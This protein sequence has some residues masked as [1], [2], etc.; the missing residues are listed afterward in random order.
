M[1]NNESTTKFKADISELKA[2][3]QEASRQIR[4]ANAEFKAASSSMED[5]GSTSEGLSAKIKQLNSVLDAEKSKLANLEKQ[6]ALT[7]AEFGENSAAADEMRIKIANQQ[8]VVNK[9]EKSLKGYVDKLDDLEKG[10]DEAADGTDELEKGLKDVKDAA[11]KAEDSAKS[12]GDGFTVLKGTMA[13]LIAD[14]ISSLIS[15]IGNVVEESR[16]YRNEMGKL[17]TAFET[18]G[19]GAEAAKTAYTDLYGI[20]GDEGAATEAAQQLAKISKNEKDLEANT[21][22]LTGVMGEYGTSIPTEG[23]AEGMAATA[24]MGEVQGVL[25][26]ALEW[27]GINLEDY[28]KKLSKLKTEEERSAFIQE[29]LLELYGDSAD[30]YMKNNAS[31][32]EANKAQADYNETMAQLGAKAEPAVTA[33]KQGFA[34][35]LTAALDLF[36]GA[37]VEGFADKISQGFSWVTENVLPPLKDG[38]QWI[39]DNKD[40]LIAGIGGVAAAML[41]MNVAN[42][43]MGVVNAFKAFKAAQEG[44]T[45]AQWL[46]NVAMNA[47]PIGLIVAAI[48]GLVA[49]FVLLWNNC[50]PFREFWIGLWEGIKNAC[51]VA[52]DAIVN[53]FTVTIPNAFNSVINWIKE[54]WDTLLT[55]LINPFAGLF[56]YF[57]EN[58]TKFKEFVDNAVNFIKELPAKVWEWL[59]Q[60]IKK[61][62]DWF[63]QMNAKAKETATNFV[64]TVVNFIKEL[65]AKIWTWLLQTINKAVT[66][67][68]NLTAKGKEAATNFVNN[69]VNFIKN[70]PSK[71]WTSLT[72]VVNKVVT[73]GSN[74]AAKGKQAATELFNAVVTKIQELPAKITSIGSDIVKG[75]WNGINNMAAWIKSKIE[76]FGDK[77][78]GSLK[79]FFGIKSPSR[80]MRDQVGKPIVQGV[81]E[82]IKRN[83]K[84]AIEA[85]D[86]MGEEL[87]DNEKFYLEEKERLEKEKADKEYQ[88]RLANAKDAAE[89]EKIKQ[90]KIKQEQE[91]AQ[92]AYL[93]NL[94]ICAEEEREVWNRMYEYAKMAVEEFE[95][96]ID[97][98]VEKQD[99][100]AKKLYSNTNAT[101]EKISFDF[102]DGKTEE[103][104]KLP[105]MSG[106][107][108]QL[109]TFSTLLDELLVKRG[110]LPE[111]V[112]EALSEMDVDEG[113]GYLTAMLNASE[114]EWEQYVASFGKRADIADKIGETLFPIDTAEALSTA[115]ENLPDEAK[116]SWEDVQAVF[117]NAPEVFG[118]IFDSAT[119]KMKPAINEGLNYLADKLNKILDD[120]QEFRVLD[121]APFS[122][123]TWRMS[124]LPVMANGGVLKRGQVGLL[125]GNGAEAVV[126]LENNSAWIRKTAKDLKAQLQA[127]GLVA[128]GSNSQTVTNNYNFT[129]NNTSPKALSRLEI[130]RQTKNQLRFARGV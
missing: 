18:S 96:A 9:T 61:V 106:Q 5:W 114:S 93:E 64:N 108:K 90:E 73:W 129:Q 66:W 12:L 13:S 62:A 47:N 67:G 100:F 31:V 69:V 85:I 3:M 20:L 109:D 70:L 98:I 16:E 123:L 121:V 58:N 119:E 86:K 37:D 77:V 97:A 48:A 117:A 43:I 87:L 25:A 22:I 10:Q 55:F 63:T 15:G 54:N 52:I 115:W 84:T 1:A 102:G 99:N 124:T 14:G 49:A 59:L 42:M 94:R 75:L 116:E 36:A 107:V 125:E 46:L 88:E 29:T 113:V 92:N 111:E 17:N 60:T 40:L 28:N 56:K 32:I 51:S 38:F 6:L 19:L 76:G 23:L 103:Y 45:V 4:L 101:F 21:R 126:P 50:E 30:A 91:E 72:D 39:I 26:D 110:D 95:A 105:D 8:A 78:L 65:P 33:V 130:Y 118:T 120:L 128:G 57:Y 112:K 81:A 44:A 82:G 89:V 68:S 79:D 27:Q 41:T 7:E 80:V 34:D 24:A 127:E 83:T 122:G 53:F 104:F 74:L 35:L 11:D 2:S 71:I